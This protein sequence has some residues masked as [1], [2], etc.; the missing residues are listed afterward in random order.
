M[1]TSTTLTTTSA[2]QTYQFFLDEGSESAKLWTKTSEKHITEL[3]RKPS[4]L[5]RAGK[6]SKA[7]AE[8]QIRSFYL[9]KGKLYY[10]LKGDSKVRGMLSLDFCYLHSYEIPDNEIQANLK[11]KI[12]L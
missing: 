7:S 8:I 2:T 1:S 4:K 12:V 9:S 11:F 3:S 10:T 5:P 6:K